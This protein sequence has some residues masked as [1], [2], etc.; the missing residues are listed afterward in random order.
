MDLIVDF[1][2]FGRMV[3]NSYLTSQRLTPTTF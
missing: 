3:A 2:V 1:H